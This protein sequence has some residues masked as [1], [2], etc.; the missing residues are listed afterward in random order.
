M[1]GICGIYRPNGQ[2]DPAVHGSVMT[3]CDMLSHRGPDDAGV[4][5]IDGATF[6]H[7]RLSIIDTTP[8][9][10]QPMWN[11]DKTILLA[12]NGEIYNYAEL[13]ERLSLHG[14]RFASDTDVEVILH[15]YEEY[16][17]DVLSHLRGMFAF[18]MYDS[19]KKRFLVARD[20]LGIKPVYYAEVDGALVFAS[21][22]KAMLASGLLTRQLDVQALDDYLSLGYTAAPRTLISGIQALLPGHLLVM[23]NGRVQTRPYWVLPQQGSNTSSIDQI[24]PETRAILEESTALHMLSDVPLG[25]FLSG[26]IDSAAVVGLMASQISEPIRT[27]TVGFYEAPEPL[28]ELAAARETARY[29]GTEHHEVMLG[30]GDVVQHLDHMIWSLD[31]PSFDGINTYLIS[32]AAKSHGITVALSGLGGDEIF[33]GYGTFSF[34]PKAERWLNLWR[35]LPVSARTTIVR[36][37]SAA[38]GSTARQQK[39][40]RLQDVNNTIDLYAMI[41]AETWIDVKQDIYSEDVKSQLHDRQQDGEI[42]RQLADIILSDSSWRQVQE[43]EIINYMGW[44]LLRD[45]DAMSMAH[46]LEIRVPLIDHKLVEYVAGL[47][48]GMERRFGHPKRLLLQSLQD[49][50]PQHVLNKPKQG[51]QFPMDIWMKNELRP[52]MDEVFSR[53]SISKRGLFEVAPMQRLYQQFKDGRLTYEVV[54]K[55]AVLELWMRQYID[56]DQSFVQAA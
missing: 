4:V 25:A 51:F 49:L 26:G 18:A 36:V 15:A 9:G 34:I 2:H 50:L 28:N 46:A 19:V 56:S 44:R 43:L 31:Q 5:E 13:R 45:A 22:I 6:G 24:I 17:D 42:W 38:I 33:G 52:I 47:P 21:E 30:G 53:A 55:F 14:H 32:R 12:A 8:R 1:C 20:R 10:H 3:M 41:R 40:R 16:G 54:W 27:F 7:R 48:A 29:F 23:E 39:L 35:A 37:L 11:E